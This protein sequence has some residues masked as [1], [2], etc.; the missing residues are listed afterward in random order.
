[1][2]QFNLLRLAAVWEVLDELTL[3]GLI[4][5]VIL[6][7][8]AAGF[9]LCDWTVADVRL[10]D[11]GCDVR[12]ESALADELPSRLGLQRKL[13]DKNQIIQNSGLNSSQLIDP[14]VSY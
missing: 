14:E 5:G 10:C 9:M 2:T 13:W 4:D 12:V 7:D 1:M 6:C 11:L 8:R 3:C